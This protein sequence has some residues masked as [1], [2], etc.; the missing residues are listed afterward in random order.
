MKKLCSLLLCLSLALSLSAPALAAETPVI[1]V[2]PEWIDQGDYI[3]FPGDPVYLPETWTKIEALRETARNG[4][5]KIEPEEG[6]KKSSIGACYELA[7]IRIKCGDNYGFGNTP[8]TR[9]CFYSMYNN[10]LWCE[11]QWLQTHEPD[12]LYYHMVVEE[13]RARIVYQSS[14]PGPADGWGRVVDALDYLGMT[15]EDLLSGKYM[16]LASQTTKDKVIAGLEACRADRK[17]LKIF[18][19]GAQIKMD[20]A[21][22][23][24]NGRTMVPIRAVAEALGA[25]VEWVPDTQ[26]IVMTRAGSTVT[27]TLGSTTATVDDKP[28]EMDVAPYAT[29]GHTL[30][31]ARYVAEFFGQKV[32][33]DG[34]DSR[35]LITED[36]S[37]AEGSNLEDWAVSM[38]LIY[39]YQYYGAEYGLPAPV[40]KPIFFGMYERTAESVKGTRDG[41]ATNWGVTGREDIIPLIQRMTPHGHNDSF[42]EAAEITNGLTDQEFAALVA[43]S[44]ETDRYMW[45]Y[46]KEISE[47]WGEKGIL[48][49]DLS[50]MSSMAQWG[51]TAGYLTYE[52]ALELVEPAAR[53]AQETFSDWDEFYLNYLDGYNWWARNDIYAARERYEAELKKSHDGALPDTYEYWMSLPRAHY[54]KDYLRNRKASGLDDALFQTGVIGLP[55]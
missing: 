43:S 29:E 53:M 11:E 44:G 42:Q 40:G 50:R 18:L 7:L 15:T 51:Y 8:D 34:K 16:Y 54:Y 26:E 19:D 23:A 55:E 20:V 36:K 38:G 2:T 35:V 37:V 39:G 27:M 4:A 28:V 9:G 10:L 14:S 17:T 3:V 49:W 24:H 32:A 21:L 41:L 13:S 1:P 12:E 25:D 52:D 5:K 22:E 30:I 31:P 48:A 46:T 45:L 47:R 6:L 33:W